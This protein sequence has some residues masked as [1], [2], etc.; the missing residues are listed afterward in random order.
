MKT[1]NLRSRFMQQGLSHKDLTAEPIEQFQSWYCDVA[2]SDLPEPTAM[3]LA[4]VDETGQ[5]W[6]RFVLLK[7]FDEQGF[8]FFTNYQSRKATHIAVNAKVN[9]LF[10]WYPLGRQVQITGIAEK[11]SASE[12][13]KYFATRPRGSQ[14]GAWASEQSHVIS[15]R[16]VLEIMVNEIKQKFADK[17][18]PLPDFWGGYRVSPSSYEF[19]QARQ[20]RLHDRFIYR[21]DEDGQWQVE[22]LAP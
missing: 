13:L 12:S 17:K 21:K 6:Q 7:I 9:L 15:S 4:T 8:V 20:D 22:R 1:E 5:P 3:S 11:I 18:V 16:S 14:I 10:P 19:W 2:D